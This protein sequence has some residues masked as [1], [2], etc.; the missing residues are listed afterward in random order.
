MFFSDITSSLQPRRAANHALMF[1]LYRLRT[2]GIIVYLID[3]VLAI[4]NE[5]D[6]RA[7]EMDRLVRK[8]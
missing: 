1:V 6:R 2:P 5:G 7:I 3:A 4:G 8:V